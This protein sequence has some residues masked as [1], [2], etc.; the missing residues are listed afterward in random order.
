MQLRVTHES[1]GGRGGDSPVGTQL[2][3][4]DSLHA[5]ERME[6][7]SRSTTIHSVKGFLIPNTLHTHTHTH[8][9]WRAQEKVCVH[10][11]PHM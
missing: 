2:K 3:K 6:V 5:R 11:S 4:S 7:K 1:V 9:H 10:G 8:N